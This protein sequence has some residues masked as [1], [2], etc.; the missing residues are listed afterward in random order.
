MYDIDVLRYRDGKVYFGQRKRL[1]TNVTKLFSGNKFTHD[2]AIE[3]LCKKIYAAFPT[4]YLV[5]YDILVTENGSMYLLEINPRPSGS[6]ISY[7]PFGVNL[8]H[9]LA[10]SY[11]DNVHIPVNPSLTG[12]SASVF[13]SLV[14]DA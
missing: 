6:T 14:K 5:D 4:T 8:Y 9:I 11:L 3:V 2:A 13:Y 10:K 12:H 7:I 1:G